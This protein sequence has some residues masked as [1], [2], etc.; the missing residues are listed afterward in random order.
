M[1]IFPA[2]YKEEIGGRGWRSAWV[3]ILVQAT[4]E[5]EVVGLGYEA[6]PETLFKKK[7]PKQKR[8]KW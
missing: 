8:L 4:E 2:K 7:K 1:L 5:A 6:N 3:K